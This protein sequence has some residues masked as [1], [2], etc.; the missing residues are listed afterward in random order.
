V[1]A[2]LLGPLVAQ[3]VDPDMSGLVSGHRVNWLPLLRKVEI[4]YVDL[5]L[6]DGVRYYDTE[7]VNNPNTT[8]IWFVGNEASAYAAWGTSENAALSLAADGFVWA[9]H[10]WDLEA[11][12]EYHVPDIFYAP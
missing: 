8:S 6:V 4:K 10:I 11:S 2:W 9:T 5:Y 3:G 7:D 1:L 12:F